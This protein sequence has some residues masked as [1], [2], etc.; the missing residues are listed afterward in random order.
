MDP[1]NAIGELLV[2]LPADARRPGRRQRTGKDLAL[3][4]LDLSGPRCCWVRVGR[5]GASRR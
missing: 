3:V 4:G 1:E 5:S 2:D